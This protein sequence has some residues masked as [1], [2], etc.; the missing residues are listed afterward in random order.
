MA[1]YLLNPARYEQTLEN[2]ALHYLGLNLPGPRELA[3]RP[4]TAV[5]LDR[6]LAC[7]YAAQRAEV[8]LRLWPRL[9]S[10]LE[11]EGL[12]EL[13]AG[14]ELPLLGTLA[15]MEARG[16]LLDQGFLRRFGQDLEV[17]MQRLEREIYALA[18]EE[19]LIQSP[20]QLGRILF[21][22]MKLTPQ[23]K[24]RGKTAYS[25]DVEVLQALEQ[26]SPIAAKGKA[27]STDV[28]V[29]QTLA[30]AHPLPAKILEY[31]T[32]GKLK[33]TYVDALLKLANPATGRVHTTFLQSVAATGRLSSRDP[34]LQNIPV[35]GSW[36]ADSPG[37]H[38]G[39]RPRLSGRGLFPDGAAASWPISPRTR[40]FSRPFR[41]GSTSTG[42]PRRRSSASTRNW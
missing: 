24:T 38:A 10:E 21:E 20:Q 34:N 2:V 13:Y 25:T 28:E 19:F 27:L 26:E 12:W 23:K 5:G 4:T 17:A 9:K 18:G 35:R 40:R 31:R 33:S 41:T 1:S 6:D 39:P 37:L 14:L 11:K 3:G 7:Q 30:A 32:M 36:G 22:K 42:R 29:L 15:R 8:A 16:I